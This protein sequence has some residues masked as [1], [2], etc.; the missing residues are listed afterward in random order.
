MHLFKAYSSILTFRIYVFVIYI[1]FISPSLYT[2]AL[3]TITTWYQSTFQ[4][5]EVTSTTKRHQNDRCSAILTISKNT[6]CIIPSLCNILSSLLHTYFWRDYLLL[7]ECHFYNGIIIDIGC[8]WKSDSG[9]KICCLL[10]ANINFIVFVL[11]WH[12]LKPTVYH[13][14]ASLLTITHPC[15]SG[16]E[17]DKMKTRT[18]MFQCSSAVLYL[19]RL[20]NVVELIYMCIPTQW[21]GC[22]TYQWYCCIM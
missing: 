2:T 17:G 5:Y 14:Q 3:Q 15:G 11:T 1:A 6:L 22:S 20:F 8:W 19:P 16:E 21:K 10:A 12:G 9:K 18:L 13:T 4:L 7:I